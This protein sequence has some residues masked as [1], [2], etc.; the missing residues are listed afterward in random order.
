VHEQDRRLDA[1]ELA[2]EAG[3]LAGVLG[4]M[5]RIHLVRS[6]HWEEV[7]A[8]RQVRG[9][10]DAAL[11]A[12]QVPVERG[13]RLSRDEL[14]LDALPFGKLD[15]AAR[16]FAELVD[17]RAERGQKLVGRYVLGLVPGLEPRGELAVSRQSRCELFVRGLEPLLRRGLDV[18]S[19]TAS[20]R[21]APADR[22]A[23]N[24][25]GD[26]LEP[27]ELRRKPV[28]PLRILNGVEVDANSARLVDQRFGVDL[29][30]GL[31]DR[32]QL[33]RAE[34]RIDE[35][36]N[37]LAEAEP[38]EDVALCDGQRGRCD[39]NE[40]TCWK[41]GRFAQ[42][43]VVGSRPKLMRSFVASARQAAGSGPCTA[44]SSSYV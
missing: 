5:S 4:V 15:E 32:L 17:E 11:Q 9:D 44:A 3:L 28:P 18:E 30:F 13:P 36:V 42:R 20:H 21:L 29:R 10:L 43:I 24:Q 2:D 39:E 19:V 25:L 38:E 26:A 23:G 22:S 6:E 7:R 33:R 40:M 35:P 1:P 37:V 14:D 31:D 12:A 16:F 41:V 27:G 34:V 8:D